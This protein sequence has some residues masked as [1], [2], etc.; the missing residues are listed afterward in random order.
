MNQ[1]FVNKLHKALCRYYV[2]NYG[3]SISQLSNWKFSYCEC[4]SIPELLEVVYKHDPDT[5]DDTLVPNA[6]DELKSLGYVTELDVEF[7]LT[8]LG[9]KAGTISFGQKSLNF[10]NSNPGIISSL[11]LLVA[12]ISLYFSYIKL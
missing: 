8:E 10:L 9:L 5:N 12:S 1:K 11:A 3:K 2:A 4:V 6:L 7:S